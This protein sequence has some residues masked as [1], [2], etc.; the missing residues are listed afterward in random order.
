MWGFIL[1]TCMLYSHDSL[2]FMVVCLLE[3]LVGCTLPLFARTY[4]HQGTICTYTTPLCFLRGGCIRAYGY[5]CVN[6]PFV[7]NIGTFSPIQAISHPIQ[8]QLERFQ[9]E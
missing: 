8:G 5:T 7:V 2:Q 4:A 9:E 1:R 6:G 3:T